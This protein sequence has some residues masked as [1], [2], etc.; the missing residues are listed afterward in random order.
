MMAKHPN[1]VQREIIRVLRHLLNEPHLFIASEHGEIGSTHEI[2]TLQNN[3]LKTLE[4]ESHAT[5]LKIQEFIDAKEAA[6]KKNIV[7][8]QIAKTAWHE[9]IHIYFIKWH[10]YFNLN[11]NLVQFENVY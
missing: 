3:I 8:E 1:F 7:E 9:R 11:L 4:V 6:D 5:R 2:K 10:Y